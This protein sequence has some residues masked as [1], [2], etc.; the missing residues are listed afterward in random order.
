MDLTDSKILGKHDE[1][2]RWAPEYWRTAAGATVRSPRGQPRDLKL[3]VPLPSDWIIM[4][5]SRNC[6][7][8]AWLTFAWLSTRASFE[9]K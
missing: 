7:L 1:Q 4:T 5:D 2:P 3:S 8:G 6:A 9:A